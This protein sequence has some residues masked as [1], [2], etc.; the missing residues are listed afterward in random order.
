MYSLLVLLFTFESDRWKKLFSAL[1]T[2]LEIHNL[3]RK[4]SLADRMMDVDAEQQ[5]I[6]KLFFDLG[7]KDAEDKVFCRIC[8]FQA[9]D[10]SLT[11]RFI[12]P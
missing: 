11:F 7:K 9:A 2:D 5:L 6:V 10:P 8:E 1:Y 3:S 12:M 4:A